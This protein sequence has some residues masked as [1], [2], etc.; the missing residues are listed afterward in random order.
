MAVM[1][2]DPLADRGV[3]PFERCDSIV[4]LAE[5]VGLGSRD[6]RRID[7][8]GAT[9]AEAMFDFAAI[10]ERRRKANDDYTGTLF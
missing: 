8:R 5:K 3:A 1:G 6:L 7:V 9:I 10:R 4:G 2:F